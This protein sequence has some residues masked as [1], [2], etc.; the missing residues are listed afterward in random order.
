MTLRRTNRRGSVSTTTT[1]WSDRSRLAYSEI[2]PDEKGLTCAGFLA[3]AAV[4]FAACGIDRNERVMTDNAWS[5]RRSTAVRAVV[6]AL[7]AKQVFIRPHCPWQNGKVER[8][9]RTLA[10]EW[11]YRQVFTSND[12]RTAA[13]APWLEHYNTGRRHSALGGHPPIS[14][15]QPTS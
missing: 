9:N 12:E 8:F 1:R 13:L 10:T 11:A 6:A 14:R 3:R 7:G 2:L 4:Y 5:Y 15:L